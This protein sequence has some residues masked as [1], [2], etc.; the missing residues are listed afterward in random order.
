MR[1]PSLIANLVKA[2]FTEPFPVT[3]A[4][5]AEL[6]QKLEDWMIDQSDTNPPGAIPANVQ[7]LAEDKIYAIKITLATTTEEVF[8]RLCRVTR[9]P[10][11]YIVQDADGSCMLAKPEVKNSSS[12]RGYYGWL[13]GNL[14]FTAR[15]IANSDG[16]QPSGALSSPRA[17]G[18]SRSSSKHGCRA[19]Y[20]DSPVINFGADTQFKSTTKLIVKIEPTITE[21]RQ[22]T[23]RRDRTERQ[24]DEQRWRFETPPLSSMDTVKKRRWPPKYVSPPPTPQPKR[25]D[26]RRNI[27]GMLDNRVTS[28]SS[29]PE[30][31]CAG[32]LTPPQGNRRSA[33][34]NYKIPS[35]PKTPKKTKKIAKK[36]P[37]ITK[38]TTTTYQPSVLE[39]L[40][41]KDV[42]LHFFLSNDS[43]GAVPVTLNEC[44]TATKFFNQALSAWNLLGGGDQAGS[45]AAVSVMIDGFHWPTVLPWGNAAAFKRMMETIAIARIGKM[46]N[47]EIRIKCLKT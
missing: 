47:F 43:L 26:K 17:K 20:L 3:A 12:R 13:G 6:V 8:T 25:S 7:R 24:T 45:M 9:S 39:P 11:V 41:T 19:K 35:P 40:T 38:P 31:L 34:V 10:M 1:D 16:F 2:G 42:V 36:S 33:R 22:A 4:S 44:N 46:G 30:L 21:V 32:P 14:G 29:S 5:E 23:L 37:I 15:T 28:R 18:G 27:G